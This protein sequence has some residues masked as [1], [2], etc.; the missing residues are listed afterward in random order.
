[1]S[2]PENPPTSDPHAVAPRKR[3]WG[4]IVLSGLLAAAVVGLAIYAIG[5]DSDLDDANAKIAAQQKQIDKAQ[6][7]GADVVAK[8][9]S[10]YEDLST[11]VGAA[12]ENAGHA[13]E[14]ANQVLDQAEQAASDAQ[15]TADELMA[16]ADAAQA[17]AE[18]AATCARSFLA[19]FS[20]VFD[21]ASLQEGV[22]A[23]VADLQDLE[24][25]C[26]SAIKAAGS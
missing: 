5:L 21:A 4:W 3:P 26:A 16:Q 2:A 20:G 1:M 19:A 6:T 25:Q 14:Q 22:D 15:G 18:T 11:Q 13:V 12:Q 8:A 24:P 10:A 17:K 9:K 7:T 23:A